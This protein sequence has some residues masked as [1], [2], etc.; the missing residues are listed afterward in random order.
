MA[1]G[2]VTSARIMAVRCDW[3]PDSGQSARDRPSC[4]YLSTIQNMLHDV[5]TLSSTRKL[6]QAALK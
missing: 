5:V 1:D 2:Q 4:Y 6:S 3:L